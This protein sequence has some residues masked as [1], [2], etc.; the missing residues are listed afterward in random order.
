MP[1]D[2]AIPL[3]SCLMEALIRLTTKF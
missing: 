1:P 3:R 2:L